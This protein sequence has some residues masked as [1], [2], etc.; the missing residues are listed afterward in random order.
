MNLTGLPEQDRGPRDGRADGAARRPAALLSRSLSEAATLPGEVQPRLGAAGSS[1]T[2]QDE[3]GRGVV[4][5][6]SQGRPLGQR[7]GTSTASWQRQ[8]PQRPGPGF[9]GSA[10]RLAR[11]GEESC[12]L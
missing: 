5:W 11:K 10:S 1:Q 4:T 12:G 9:T 6:R 3:K 8:E 2:E 7:R